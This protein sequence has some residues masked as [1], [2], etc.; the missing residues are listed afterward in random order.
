VGLKPLLSVVLAL[1]GL[2][3]VAPAAQAA[4]LVNTVPPSISGHA[5]FDAELVA[6][7]GEWAP[8]ATSYA[9]RWLRDGEPIKKAREATYH[10][11]LDDLGHR[12]SVRVTASDDTGQTGTATSAETE[13]IER[14][15][16]RARSGQK[17]AGVARYTHALTARL[18]RWNA[19]PT[20]VRFQWRR[21]GVDIPGATDQRFAI[22]PEDLGARLRVRITAKAPGYKAASITTD[23]TERV[24]HRVDVRRTIRYHIETRG[25]ITASVRKFA[26]QAQETFDDPRGWRAAGIQFRR[27]ARAGSM[28]LVLAQARTVPSFS[29]ACSAEWSCRVGRF[30]IINQTRWLHASPAWNAANGPLRGY[31]HMVV[32]HETGHFL[33]LGHAGCPG[34]GR[35]APVM[36]QQSKGLHGCRFNSWPI[37]REIA[38]R[39][40]RPRSGP[41]ERAMAWRTEPSYPQVM[42]E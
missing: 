41:P 8:A 18:G 25:H 3:V 12:I 19:E 11:G 7:P 2:A 16:L 22:R 10:P 31:R 17:V 42:A 13:R 38:S 15:Q 29:S 30:V 1:V 32:N 6:D 9:Y 35:P 5:K 34:K 14:A 26:A 4:E 20:R 36:M 39:T 40:P 28:T 27:V 24:R 21:N 37:A 33:G 23:R